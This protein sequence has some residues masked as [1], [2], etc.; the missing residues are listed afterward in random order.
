MMASHC[1]HSWYRCLA[2]HVYIYKRNTSG[3]LM[4][5]TLR[6]SYAAANGWPADG[7][8]PATQVTI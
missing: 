4:M 2:V 6:A 7:G 3:K 5:K 8:G 1:Y